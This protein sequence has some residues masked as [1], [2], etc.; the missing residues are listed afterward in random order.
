MSHWGIDDHSTAAYRYCVLCGH[1]LPSVPV[2]TACESVCQS[3]LVSFSFTN[4]FL[5]V[6]RSSSAQLQ[7]SLAIYP[8]LI[9]VTRPLFRGGGYGGPQKSL[10]KNFWIYLFA[11]TLS[12]YVYFCYTSADVMNIIVV[13]T[14]VLKCAPECIKMQH[15]EGENTKNFQGRGYSDLPRPHPHLEYV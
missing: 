13:I 1:V 6:C 15:F 2:S 9:G 11:E 8:S 14:I 12:F 5:S 7:P 10:H 3:C 4:Q